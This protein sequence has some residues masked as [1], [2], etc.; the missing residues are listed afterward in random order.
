MEVYDRMSAEDMEDCEEFK[1]D[2]QRAY[3]LWPEA[4][5]LQ[6]HGG[7]KRKECARYFEETFEKWIASEQATSFRKLKELIV[8]EQSVNV[9]EEFVKS[10]GGLSHI[11]LGVHLVGPVMFRWVPRPAQLC[12]EAHGIVVDL[13]ISLG[14]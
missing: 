12:L 6:V 5:M 8:L 9:E 4:Y 1:A 7:K 3:E 2:T 10:K 14:K 13:A 11:G